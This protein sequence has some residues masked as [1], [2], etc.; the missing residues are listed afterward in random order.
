MT[1]IVL[2][3][4]S[5]LLQYPVLLGDALISVENGKLEWRGADLP[6]KAVFPDSSYHPT[7]LGLI[8]PNLASKVHLVH[9]RV[10]V[11]WSGIKRAAIS[12]LTDIAVLLEG[13]SQSDH[14][15]ITEIAAVLEDCKLDHILLHVNSAGLP[16]Y[17]VHGDYREFADPLLGRCYTLGSGKAHFGCPGNSAEC[18]KIY[19]RPHRCR[20]IALSVA[21]LARRP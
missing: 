7:E 3:T 20:T 4:G 10:A 9:P 12:A 15:P 21:L 2:A 17:R 16:A 8:S 18:L 14:L 13:K 5:S 19:L 1:L 6:L 11:A